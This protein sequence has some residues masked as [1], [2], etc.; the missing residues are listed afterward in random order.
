MPDISQPTYP[1]RNP[2]TRRFI[3]TTAT[4]AAF[5]AAGN[6]LPGI[7]PST[8]RPEATTDLV[9]TPSPAPTL[10]TIGDHLVGVHTFGLAQPGDSLAVALFLQPD[11][12]P[13][14][15][16]RLWA[17]LKNGWGSV[18]SRSEA[19]TDG[20]HTACI[21]LPSPLPS[22]AR[23]WIGLDRAVGRPGTGSVALPLAD[24]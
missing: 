7:S 2:M 9:E 17:G 15:G 3:L 24:C 11:L 6:P 10:L 8:R 16:I 21:L 23:L 13:P 22:Q 1:V 5:L 14:A 12:P 18:I 4:L 19:L 20:V